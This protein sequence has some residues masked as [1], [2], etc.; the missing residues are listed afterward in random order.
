MA[1]TTPKSQ[2]KTKTLKK[3]VAA[4]RT[5]VKK[6]EKKLAKPAK[7]TVA[8]KVST[9]A[10]VYQSQLIQK[11]AL[12]L[13]ALLAAVAFVYMTNDTRSFSLSYMVRD[14]V[15]SQLQNLTVFAPAARTLAEV[16]VKWLLITLLA[17]SALFPILNLTV[18]K[19]KYETGAATGI[20]LYRWIETGVTTG[21]M[22]EIAALLSGVS[23]IAV[24]KLLVGLVLLW[25]LLG[26]LADRQNAAA[27]LAQ[28]SA[29]YLSLF[30]GV[31][32]FILIG[33]TAGATLLYGMIRSPW[34]VYALYAVLLLGFTDV[35][36]N[37][38]FRYRRRSQWAD[39]GFVERNY[40]LVGLITKVLFAG[41][42]ILGF[43][44]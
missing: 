2:A 25:A 40:T 11:A 23:D 34:Y 41:V 18:W 39:A 38:L 44:K 17:V 14:Q 30:A 16:P 42:L 6:T 10:L 37:Q 20:N 36:I 12:I 8:A 22:V 9:K 5:V 43:L 35:V 1:R 27:G 33:M 15:A 29:F 19:D 3:P 13:F 31:L 21:L 24:L 28:R 7:S 26:W 32:P 4:K